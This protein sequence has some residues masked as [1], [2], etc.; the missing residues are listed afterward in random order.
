M[1]ENPSGKE[2]VGFV[3]GKGAEKRGSFAS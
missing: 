2:T 3:K 1:I